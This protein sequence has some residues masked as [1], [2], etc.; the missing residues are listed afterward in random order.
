MRELPDVCV[1]A[2]VLRRPLPLPQRAVSKGV[3][4]GVSSSVDVSGAL[5]AWAFHRGGA[6]RLV[7]AAQHVMHAGDGRRSRELRGSRARGRSLQAACISE[8]KI[9]YVR[10]RFLRTASRIATI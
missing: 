8:T 7:A 4:T 5:C 10:V 1:R 9:N 6:G 2:R 3:E